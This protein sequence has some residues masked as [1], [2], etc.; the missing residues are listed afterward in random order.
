MMAQPPRRSIF[1]AGRMQHIIWGLR[2]GASQLAVCL[3]LVGLV[4]PGLAWAAAPLVPVA[5]AVKTTSM[6]VKPYWAELT[7][8][9]RQTLAPLQAEWEDMDSARKKKWMEIAN[10]YPQMKP[11]DQQRAQQRMQE[12]AQ[13]TPEQRRVARDSYARAQALPPEKRAELLKAYQALPEEK[14]QQLAKENKSAKKLVS[15][16][17]VLTP[18]PTHA[19]IRQGVALKTSTAL[20]K[21]ASGSATSVNAAQNTAQ[22]AKQ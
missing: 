20:N 16:Q 17:P 4:P 9:Q 6:A 13:L 2:C 5:T 3:G 21:A 12:W 7:P 19:Q 10:R 22:V 1:L 14:K 18:V 15:H 11:E 8:L